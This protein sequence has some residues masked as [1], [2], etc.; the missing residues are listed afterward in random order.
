MRESVRGIHLQSI[1]GRVFRPKWLVL[2]AAVLVVS[3]TAAVE[4]HTSVIQSAFFSRWAGELTYSVE[5]VPSYS[6]RFPVGGPQDQRLGYDKLPSFID[7]LHS[8][9]YSIVR[10]AA[11]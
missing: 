7:S 9:D 11:P 4:L 3:L 10:Q 1:S 8:R 5:P 6:V 2:G